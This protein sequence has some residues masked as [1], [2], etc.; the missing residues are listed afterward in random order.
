ME[1]TLI[2]RTGPAVHYH[3]TMV[4]SSEI[5]NAMGQRMVDG[6]VLVSDQ[7]MKIKSAMLSPV[8]V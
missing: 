1:A 2:G 8:Q 7:L 3:V 5:D 4:L 6:T